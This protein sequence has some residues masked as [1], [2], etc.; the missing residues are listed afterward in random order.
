MAGNLGMSSN[1]IGEVPCVLTVQVELRP[2]FFLPVC[3]NN[4]Y[5]PRRY[6]ARLK[7]AAILQV[8]MSAEGEYAAVDFQ[9]EAVFEA[10]RG[11]GV[12]LLD[13]L[14]NRTHTLSSSMAASWSLR[15]LKQASGLQ[16]FRCCASL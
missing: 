11:L 12:S 2:G 7:W 6:D 8:S 9:L 5:L 10:F 14:S 3:F 16:D 13:M 4:Y 1:F 15:F